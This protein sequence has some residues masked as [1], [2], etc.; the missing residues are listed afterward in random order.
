M[1][2]DLTDLDGNL[3]ER[4]RVLCG[5]RSEG[6]Y[7]VIYFREYVLAGG[8]LWIL[9]C[10]DSSLVIGENN[11]LYWSFWLVDESGNYHFN[12]VELGNVYC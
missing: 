2:G 10:L 1:C 8:S 9:Y 3:I 6:S 4:G 11:H 5:C 7:V 12:T